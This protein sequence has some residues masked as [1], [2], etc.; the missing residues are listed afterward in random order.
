MSDKGDLQPGTWIAVDT[1]EMRTVWGQR[2]PVVKLGLS[3]RTEREIPAPAHGDTVHW[4]GFLYKLR[5]FGV[6]IVLEKYDGR[7]VIASVDLARVDDP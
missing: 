4:N 1:G 5:V 6:T 2:I 3:T 7:Y